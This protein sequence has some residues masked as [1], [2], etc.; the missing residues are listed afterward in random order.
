MSVITLAE[1][2]RHLRVTHTSDDLLI[3][4]LIDAAENE[5]AQFMNREDLPRTDAEA[6][7]FLSDSDF[8]SDSDSQEA[9][10]DSDDVAPS[11][12]VAVYFLV[13]AKYD[14]ADTA[15]REG[16]RKTAEGLLWPYRYRLGF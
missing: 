10:S 16:L 5:A 2:K 15:E 4:T 14:A 8:D 1:V 6:P 7:E 12:R 11:V 9:A 3:Q 13:Q